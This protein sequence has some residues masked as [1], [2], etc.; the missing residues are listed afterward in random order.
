MTESFEQKMA[1]LDAVVEQLED[2]K[3]GLE[4]SLTAFQQGTELV[5]G[6]KDMLAQAEV[7]VK[8]IMGETGDSELN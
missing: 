4:D 7:R 5:K 2:G 8:K 3:L 6:L 1:K